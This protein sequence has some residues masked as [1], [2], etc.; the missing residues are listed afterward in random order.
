MNFSEIVTAIN[1]LVWGPVMLMLLVGTGIFLTIRLKFLPWRNLGYALKS[2][3]VKTEKTK[4]KKRGDISPFQS[5]MTSLAATI[6]TG[7]IVGVA[8]AMVLGGP[9]ALVW[10]WISAL[11]GLSTKYGESVLAIKYRE[12]NEQG[13]MSG[14]PMYAMKNGIKIKWLGS[15]MAVLF[16]VFAVAA[17][18]GIGN[19]TQ[20]NSISNAV[21]GTFGVPTWITG[22]IITGLAITVLLGG[23]KSIGKVCGIIVPFMAVLYF[24]AALT[25]IIINYENVP[26]GIAEIFT[27][28]F[29]PTAIAGGVGGTIIA[30]MLTAMRWGVARGVFS[31][32]AGLGSAP[33]AAAAAV[34]D[35]PSRQGYINMTGTFFDTLVTCSITGIVI[36]SSG[37]LGSVDASGNLVTGVNLTIMAFQSALGPAGGWIITIG[38]MLFA[39]ST[40]LGWEYYGEKSLEY[41]IRAPIAT[42][43]YRFV[44]CLV[45]FIGSTI[46]LE[47]VWDTMNGLMAIPN[48]ICLLL[49]SNVIAKECFDYQDRIITPARLA[50]KALKNK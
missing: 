4:K 37:A 18:F 31:N 48:L 33:I 17:S 40:I 36:A 2:I 21:Y 6:G 42:K 15:T 45:T 46:A 28:A 16:S 9:G 19:M 34:T 47:I 23:I 38:I 29:S 41:L 7:N 27:M 5:L 43:I 44:Y 8:T 14:G 50:R 22:L 39:F 20:A 24:I 30:S 49:L 32:E 12:T 25:V 11:F 3:F 13:E 35:Y 1:N 10:M 26:A